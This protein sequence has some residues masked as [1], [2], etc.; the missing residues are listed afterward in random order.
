MNWFDGVA[1]LLII[2]IAWVESMRGFGRAIF[3]FVGGLIA[4]KV[5]IFVS[6]PLA[7]A[8]PLMA[9]EAGGEAFWMAMV[10][11]ILVV[12]IVV[13]TKF[14]YET[15]LMSLDV[16]DPVVG[17][18]LGVASGCV[19]A[20]LFLRVML[21]AYADTDFA[22]VVLHSFVGQEIIA[23]RS[24]HRVVQGLQNLGNW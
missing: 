15:T 5:S 24:Y 2:V 16:L 17:G 20:H 4:L 1:I 23:F 10:F 22:N 7:E 8:A 12:L 21:A 19:V 11:L 6:R 13:A 3:D 14:I 18:I 9:S